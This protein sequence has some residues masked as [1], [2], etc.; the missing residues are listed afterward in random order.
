MSRL[1]QNIAKA[2]AQI[3]L[4]HFVDALG[5]AA[6]ALAAA[7]LLVI[8]VHKA[9][10]YMLPWP[11]TALSAAAA[12]GILAAIVV[13]LWRRPNP[14]A[15]A[16]AI[17]QKLSL[18]ERFSSALVLRGNRDRFA[19]AAV[20]DAE[21][22]AQRIA[23]PAHE[24]FPLRFPRG[25]GA[26]AALLVLILLAMTLPQAHWPQSSATPTQNNRVTPAKM[27][28]AKATIQKALAQVDALPAA[29]QKLTAVQIAH[30]T[31]AK[32]ASTSTDPVSAQR[33]A[34]SALADVD[35]ALQEQVQANGKFV[36][37]QKEQQALAELAN[38][39]LS[40]GSPLASVQ[41]AMAQGDLA[42]ATAEL[43]N[44]VTN[45][46]KLDASQ[47]KQVAADMQKLAAKLKQM[48]DSPAGQ[49]QMQQQLQALGLNQQQAQHASDL[50]QH[51]AAGDP[52]AQQ[53]L[54]QL[55]QQSLA[56]M[57]NGQG[58]TPQQQQQ[59]QRMLSQMQ[60]QSAAQMRAGQMSQA[61]SQLAAAM[62]QAAGAK[63][64]QSGQGG[65]SS[66]A[67]Q[68]GQNQQSAQRADGRSDQDSSGLS[69]SA[70]AMNDAMAQIQAVRQ[71]AQQMQAAQDSVAD[72]QQQAM[73]GLPAGDSGQDAGNDKDDINGNAAGQ[74]PGGGPHGF[75]G[76]LYK[77]AA[78]YTV[79]QVMSPS[80]DNPN[81]RILAST[82]VKAGALRGEKRAALRDVAVAAQQDAPDEVDQDRVSRQAQS[83]VKEYFR[84]MEEDGGTPAASGP[85]GNAP[86]SDSPTSQPAG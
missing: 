35:K 61:A 86:S 26:A 53:Q 19:M 64:P 31:L 83:A 33:T 49:Q 2:R 44:L 39:P 77:T 32:A 20:A 42:K 84:S 4:G 47:Q 13:A 75:G 67:A 50:I 65:Q 68:A 1:D 18:R 41:Q 12:A 14:H 43:N 69:Q 46:N 5:A 82:L 70:S 10:G 57:N 54:Q 22:T 55:A 81:G 85:P 25:A 48:A 24:L 73:D 27:D 52:A 6:A 72:A 29:T 76:H 17:D 36:E 16:V 38:Q 71:D 63:S 11:G 15:A 58:P 21:A 66:Q 34:A 78:P 80:Q 45:F 51:A 56:Q 74:N 79:K 40:E 23:M 37:S 30:E 59:L 28:L 9:L 7:I 60:G 8:L 62:Q 3:A